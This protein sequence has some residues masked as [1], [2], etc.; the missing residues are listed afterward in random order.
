MNR[1]SSTVYIHVSV[2][3]VTVVISLIFLAPFFPDKLV[4]LQVNSLETL[5]I[6]R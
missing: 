6:E 1:I 4:V 3:E 5:F 2:S